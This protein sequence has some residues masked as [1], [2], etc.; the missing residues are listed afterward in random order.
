MNPLS[1]P[2]K[3]SRV[4]LP[5]FRAALIWHR[6]ASAP[7]PA[8][9]WLDARLDEDRPFPQEYDYI[10]DN[11]DDEGTAG[12]AESYREWDELPAGA[13][14]P[15]ETIHQY[16]FDRELVSPH[17]CPWVR[18]LLDDYAAFIDQALAGFYQE[19]FAWL[20]GRRYGCADRYPLVGR[21]RFIGR[22]N[23]YVST[24]YAEVSECCRRMPEDWQTEDYDIVFKLLFHSYLSA[25]DIHRRVKSYALQAWQLGVAQVAWENAH[26]GR[27][28]TDA[29]VA[30]IR[31][32]STAT[33]EELMAAHSW[34]MT[35]LLIVGS[36]IIESAASVR[37]RLDETLYML[38]RRGHITEYSMANRHA[39]IKHWLYQLSARLLQ[40]GLCEISELKL[41]GFIWALPYGAVVQ[42]Q[43]DSGGCHFCRN[44]DGAVLTVVAPDKPDKDRWHE[45]WLGKTNRDFDNVPESYFENVRHFKEVP[46]GNIFPHFRAKWR[47]LS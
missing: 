13:P 23:K 43:E 41:Q 33:L 1:P 21:F 12:V 26:P 19:A 25:T 15:F 34:D 39:S 11:S 40:Y 42:R 36:H 8:G 17:P 45:V 22:Y 24:R 30:A 27:E 20:E 2:N 29:E 28:P 37:E 6:I 10:P 4:A 32:S 3:K 47:R 46:A 14:C 7:A 44:I 38:L 35:T 16:M 31:Q 9:D 18:P 5:A